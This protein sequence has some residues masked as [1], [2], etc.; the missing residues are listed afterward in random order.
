VEA[1]PP[2]GDER[3]KEEKEDDDGNEEEDD[4]TSFQKPLRKRTNCKGF[5]IS[6]VVNTTIK[7]G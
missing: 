5:V 3:K 7:V 1:V 2:N 6:Y 4:K